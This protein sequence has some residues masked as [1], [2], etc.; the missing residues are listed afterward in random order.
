MNYVLVMGQL[1]KEGDTL[2]QDVAPGLP[3]KSDLA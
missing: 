1:V 3:I 2:H